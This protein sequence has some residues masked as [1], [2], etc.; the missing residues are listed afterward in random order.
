MSGKLKVIAFIS[1]YELYQAGLLLIS[2][3]Q[4]GELLWENVQTLLKSSEDAYVV[5]DDTVLDKRYGHH[6]ELSRRLYSGTE[7]RVIRG[8]S[9]SEKGVIK[10]RC[11]R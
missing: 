4:S 9:S 11:R 7:H 1:A 2:T 5:F 8:I 10:L 6:I 3:K